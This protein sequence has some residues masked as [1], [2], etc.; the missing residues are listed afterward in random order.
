M[1]PSLL[2]SSALLLLALLPCSPSHAFFDFVPTPT[3]WQAWPEYCR[4]EYAALMHGGG[5]STEFGEEYSPTTIEN[6]RERLGART[7]SG[8]HHYCA[9][10]HWLNRSQVETDK[11]ERAFKL[12]TALEEV[13][14]SAHQAEPQ[15]VVY[16]EIMIMLSRVKVEMGDMEGATA[17][18]QK[19]IA[20]QPAQVRPYGML[21]M[22]YRKQHQLGQAKETLEKADAVAQGKSAE[23]QYNLGLINLELGDVD[24]AVANAR[25]A[26]KM[27]YPLPW[28]KTRL[29]KMGKW[30]AEG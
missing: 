14:Y 18:L 12:N 11:R 16:P 7:F 1:K 13:L 3:E 28:L 9:G 27:D 22:I 29:Q 30:P 6:W 4:V 10:I 2:R 20:A 25:Q 26:Y 23:I 24:A 5:Q 19:T 21:A 8:I 15:S 17:A